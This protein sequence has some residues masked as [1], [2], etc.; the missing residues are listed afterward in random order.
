MLGDDLRIALGMA[1]EHARARKH[2]YLTTEHLLY[3]LLHDLRAAEILEATEAFEFKVGFDPRFLAD[4]VGQ[5]EWAI[6]AGLAKRPA[7]DL[8]ALLRSLIH[9]GPV[10]AARPDRVT[11]A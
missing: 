6:A 9:V 10:K 11:L 5:A 3:G 4:L 2:E 7:G 1:L 8:R